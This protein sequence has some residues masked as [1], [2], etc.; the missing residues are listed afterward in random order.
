MNHSSFDIEALPG[1][2]KGTVFVRTWVEELDIDLV[3]KH[4]GVILKKFN[5]GAPHLRGVGNGYFQALV[6]AQF[7]MNRPVNG[8]GVV[9]VSS[10]AQKLDIFGLNEKSE[11]QLFR[12]PQMEKKAFLCGLDELAVAFHEGPFGVISELDPV[13]G[14]GF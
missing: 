14:L 8:H 3:F 9:P 2:E 13:L 11:L 12:E 4:H 5:L 1:F 7:L 10:L 6:R